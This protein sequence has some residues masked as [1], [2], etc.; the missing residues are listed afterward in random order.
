MLCM[1]Q[2][3]RGAVQRRAGPNTDDPQI[4]GATLHSLLL[5]NR[6]SVHSTVMLRWRCSREEVRAVLEQL[7]SDSLP[8]GHAHPLHTG[9]VEDLKP[10]ALRAHDAGVL[11]GTSCAAKY[12]KLGRAPTPERAGFI[13]DSQ[14]SVYL[15][16]L[17][18]TSAATA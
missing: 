17:D 11:A 15:C 6:F 4:S 10:D 13:L 5:S 18:K 9:R 8:M 3:V 14:A 12:R 7:V 16:S 2:L 1:L